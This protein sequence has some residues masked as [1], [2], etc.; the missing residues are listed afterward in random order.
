MREMG[1]I[2][3]TELVM[4]KCIA[5]LANFINVASKLHSRNGT[6]GSSGL[7]ELVIMPQCIAIWVNFINVTI[8]QME[9]VG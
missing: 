3:V 6:N 4:Q 9:A 7:T 8:K 5:I 2:V 1:Q